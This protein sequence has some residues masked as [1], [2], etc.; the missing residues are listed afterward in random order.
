MNFEKARACAWQERL[1]QKDDLGQNE[2]EP[3]AWVVGGSLIL[4]DMYYN[5]AGVQRNV[6]LAFR[7]ACEWENAA[8]G[9]ALEHIEKD[10]LSP[11][12]Q[13]EFC[14]YATTTF[15]MNFCSGY[16][17]EIE[18]SRRTRYYESLQSSMSAGQRDAFKRLLDA[19]RAYLE[20]HGS[21]VDQ[22]GTIRVVRTLES[23]KIL[24]ERFYSQLV[25]FERKE[26]PRMSQTQVQSADR[27]LNN[28]YAKTI[29]QLRNQS[30]ED[31]YEGSVTPDGLIKAE[32]SWIM[33]RDAWSEFAKMRY[34]S[35]MEDIVAEIVIDRYRLLKTIP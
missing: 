13:V 33:Y 31:S 4:A 10:G 9:L 30:K 22:G 35:A 18:D 17:S 7:F 23:E 11:K 1:A 16:A 21:E 24:K 5:G 32:R 15:T 29:R 27:L 14:D 2:H 20:A 19:Q 28:Q 6:P 34:P 3:S 8:V 25:R 12:E 26:W